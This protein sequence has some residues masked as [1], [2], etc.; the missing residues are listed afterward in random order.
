MKT[1]LIA[2]L[3]LTGCQSYEKFPLKIEASSDEQP[4]K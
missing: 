3:L 1:C 2:L 4:P